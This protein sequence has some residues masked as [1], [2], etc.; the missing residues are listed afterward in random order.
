M[1]GRRTIPVAVN[2][3]AFVVVFYATAVALETGEAQFF[4][5][6]YGLDVALQRE[7]ASGRPY[8]GTQF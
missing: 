4:P 7:L 3:P 2:A 6:L 8:P 1:R 5:D